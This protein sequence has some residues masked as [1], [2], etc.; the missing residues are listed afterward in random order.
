MKLRYDLMWRGTQWGKKL[1]KDGK[2]KS[3]HKSSQRLTAKQNAAKFVWKGHLSS[4]M[5]YFSLFCL[6]R[7][8]QL[9][10]FWPCAGKY[11][12]FQFHLAIIWTVNRS[13]V[14]TLNLACHSPSIQQQHLCLL[15][16]RCLSGEVRCCIYGEVGHTM[17]SHSDRNWQNRMQ[18]RCKY[19]STLHAY[20]CRR[21]D[22]KMK[23]LKMMF[24]WWMAECCG[25]CCGEVEACNE[26][27]ES[28]SGETFCGNLFWTAS[29]FMKTCSG[30]LLCSRKW[31]YWQE[32]VE[33]KMVSSTF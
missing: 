6:S 3:S 11:M 29:V 22:S 1:I 9:S 21:A 7:P 15:L 31:I 2:R 18:S 8:V 24:K 23:W 27:V 33:K 17:R 10:T 14:W 13:S 12:A 19:A 32:M 28:E 4:A 26:N 20:T 25:E 16:F 5:C 30:Q